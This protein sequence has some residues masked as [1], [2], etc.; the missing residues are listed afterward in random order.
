VNLLLARAA[1][2]AGRVD[3]ALRLEQRVAEAADGDASE[4]EAAIAQAWTRVR[5]AR[6]RSESQDPAI[7]AAVLR[8]LRHSG[9]LR[10]PPALF[11]ALTWAHPDDVISMT[12]AYP[13]AVDRFEPVQLNSPT[14][15]IDALTLPDLDEGALR[16][17][18]ERGGREDLRAT[19]ATL[20]IVL[21]LGTEQE[22]ILRETVRLD[23]ETRRVVMRLEAGA[24]TAE[25]AR[26]TPAT[27]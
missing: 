21:G 8:R 2:D 17:A 16:L 11:A 23:R 13:D 20:T 15:G 3:E 18:F 10:S 25:P 27:P 24:L 26:A 1:A 14:H 5:L 6:L 7:D 22:R 4:G 12:V 19:E 9:A